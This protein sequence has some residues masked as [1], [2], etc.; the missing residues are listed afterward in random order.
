MESNDIKDRIV[1]IM[2]NKIHQEKYDIYNEY[3]SI[4]KYMK[5]VH[6]VLDDSVYGHEDAK[7]QIE[8]II[9]QW[10]TGKQSGYCFGFEEITPV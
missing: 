3:K 9:G 6:K 5:S 2:Q 8:R 4:H 10:I 7:K 1:Q